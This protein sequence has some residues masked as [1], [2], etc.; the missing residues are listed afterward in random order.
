M[1]AD[2]SIIRILRRCGIAGIE[3]C[4]PPGTYALD[5]VIRPVRAEGSFDIGSTHRDFTP[6]QDEF[7]GL[8]F[9]RQSAGASDPLIMHRCIPRYANIPTALDAK[10]ERKGPARRRSMRADSTRLSAMAHAQWAVVDWIRLIL[11]CTLP[12]ISYRHQTLTFPSI[13]ELSHQP[14]PAGLRVFPCQP[15]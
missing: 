6:V 11:L 1:A 3:I 5:R 14:P 8:A 2:T 7:D 9:L 15:C 4:G 12:N 13:V 10:N